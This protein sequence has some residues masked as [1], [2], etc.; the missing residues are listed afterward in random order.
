MKRFHALIVEDEPILAETLRATLMRRW[1]EL[2]TRL[3]QDGFEGVE[4]ALATRPD[5]LF[6]DIKMPGKSGIEVAHELAEEW[7]ETQPFPLIVFVTA[8]NDYA[9]QAFDHAAV[10]YLLKPVSEGRLD[11]TLVRIRERLDARH[12][13]DELNRVVT[14]LHALSSAPIKQQQLDFIRAAVG[15]QIRLIPVA[16]VLFFQAADKYLRVITAAGEALIR[17]SL[18]DLLPQLDST[19]FWQIHRGTVVNASAIEAAIRDENGKRIVRVRG[20]DE[21]LVVS[22]VFAHLFRQM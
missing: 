4:L 18:K 16:D 5:V 14:Q 9:L 11:T 3:A 6:L 2:E 12:G 7:P 1:P 17:T 20:R 15:T 22:R 13:S 8:Y 10:D 21:A 19:R